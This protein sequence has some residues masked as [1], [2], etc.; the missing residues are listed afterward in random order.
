MQ[1][2][3]T[4]TKLAIALGVFLAATTSQNADAS[5]QSGVSLEIAAG[6]EL[7]S[8]DTTYQIGGKITEPTGESGTVHF[9]L[10]ELEWPLDMWMAGIDLG[11]HLGN[12][13][14]INGALKKN[15]S[16]PDDPMK[17]SDWGIAYLYGL[18]GASPGDLDIYSESDITSFDA[19]I[20]DLNVEWTIARPGRT[21]ISIGVGHM[22]QEFEY[23]AS[24]NF[25]EEYYLGHLIDRMTGDDRTAITYDITYTMTYVLVGFD[26]QFGPNTKMETQFAYSPQTDAD[27]EDHHLLRENGGK[28]SKGDMDDKAYMLEVSF[29]HD[30]TPMLFVEAG[31]HFTKIEVEGDQTQVYGNG[32][33]LGTI[34]E[35]SESTQLSEFLRLGVA[36]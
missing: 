26:V 17:D 28:I 30:F 27:D 24:L 4:F 16:E 10:S 12:S 20:Y 8:G 9:P 11:L 1:H 25:Q 3:T 21:A 2:P 14:T 5:S 33:P 19:T 35:K 18:P 7:W 29:R 23:E 36:L 15:M 31:A 6:A 34:E 13:F 32:Q 22:K